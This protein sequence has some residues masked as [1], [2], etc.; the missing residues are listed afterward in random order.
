MPVSQMPTAVISPITYFIDIINVGLGEASGFG[1]FGLLFDF[2]A[3]I[4]IGII[5]LIL[6]FTLHEK[7]LQKRFRG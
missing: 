2:T 4:L 3:I 5:F 6:A 1:E 7:T